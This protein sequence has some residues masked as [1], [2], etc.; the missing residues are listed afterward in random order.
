MV[1][2]FRLL[3]FLSCFVAATVSAAAV[4]EHENEEHNLSSGA[5]DTSAG[6]YDLNLHI[7][8]VFLLLVSSA[9]GVFAPLILGQQA[10]KRKWIAEMFFV[11]SRVKRFPSNPADLS[12][13]GRL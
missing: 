12:G 11:S 3:A 13:P 4:D 10:G 9:F 2:M 5:C 6:S 8:A 7:M 1:L